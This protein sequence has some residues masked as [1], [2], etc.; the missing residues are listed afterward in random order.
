[1]F[2]QLIEVKTSEPDALVA[3]VAGYDLSS[4][5]GLR[6]ANVYRDRNRDD[7]YFIEAVFSS[8]DEAEQ[9]SGREETDRWAAR[10]RELVDEDPF[11]CDL[12]P[13]AEFATAQKGQ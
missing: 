12:E 11:Y 6:E 13:A 5:V 4:A 8:R 7:V 3:H 1:M 9:N 10:L 2:K